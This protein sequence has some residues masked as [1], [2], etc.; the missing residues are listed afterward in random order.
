M[1]ESKE[2][3]SPKELAKMLGITSQAIRQNIMDGK[4]KAS[5]PLGRWR[6]HKSEVERLTK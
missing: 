5:K 1:S 4:I 6:I 3:Y 2:W